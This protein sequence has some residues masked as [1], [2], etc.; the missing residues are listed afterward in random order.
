MSN[1]IYF[2]KQFVLFSQDLVI[3]LDRFLNS[4][5][6]KAKLFCSFVY[7][8]VLIVLKYFLEYMLKNHI[9]HT[10]HTVKNWSEHKI[11]QHI[12]IT[13]SSPARCSSA[14]SDFIITNQKPTYSHLPSI[15]LGVSTSHLCQLTLPH[16]Q[17]P[18]FP[19]DKCAISKGWI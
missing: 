13:F 17:S 5:D 2:E 15:K 3:L 7:V 9:H 18:R 4:A 16:P 14:V 12:F 6:T 10:L 8:S 19:V 1:L 11:V